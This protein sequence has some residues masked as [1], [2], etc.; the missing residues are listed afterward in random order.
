MDVTFREAVPFYG[1]K[2][3]LNFLLESVS[4]STDEG[5]REGE[6]RDAHVDLTKQQSNK[7]EAV[8]GDPPQRMQIVPSEMDSNSNQG[9]NNSVGDEADSSSNQGN[10]N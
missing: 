10:N 3:D 2:S 4:P 9:N 6:N 1:E 5:S 8:I 7:M